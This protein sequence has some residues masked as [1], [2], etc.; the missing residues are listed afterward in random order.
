MFLT[1]TAFLLQLRNGSASSRRRHDEG[2]ALQYP[3]VAVV[4]NSQT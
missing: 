1:V 4:N 2:G 3:I